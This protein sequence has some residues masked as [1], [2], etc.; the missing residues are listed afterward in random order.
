MHPFAQLYHFFGLNEAL[1]LAINRHHL[2]V[3][4]AL[5][6]LGSA[7]GNFW[8]F[9]AVAAVLIA[10]AA[11]PSWR[12]A[13]R[14]PAAWPPRE[15]VLRLL[16]VLTLGYVIAMAL[17]GAL[18]YGLHL[19]RPPAALGA[20]AVRVLGHPETSGSFPSGHATFAALVAAAFWGVAGLARRAALVAW[21]LWVL[22]VVLSRMVVGAHFPADLLAG[23]LCGLFSTWAAQ[24]LL[25]HYARRQRGAVARAPS[26]PSPR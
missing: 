14:L 15:N 12:H 2:A 25:A 1:F 9:P 20:Q 5:S 7:L 3:F 21:V 19:P 8:N 16:L 18:K 26:R 23:V 13:R 11:A 22:W 24:R 6:R 10:I 4:D 17:V